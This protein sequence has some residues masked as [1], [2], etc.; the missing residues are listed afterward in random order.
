VGAISVSAPIDRL[1][2]QQAE[3]IAQAAKHTADKIGAAL[4]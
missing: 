2:P 4:A 1:D 3:Q